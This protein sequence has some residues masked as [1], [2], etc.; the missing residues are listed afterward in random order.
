MTLQKLQRWILPDSMFSKQLKKLQVSAALNSLYTLKWCIN[1]IVMHIHIYICLCNIYGIK[2]VC[3]LHY[4]HITCIRLYINVYKC[5][6]AVDDPECTEQK[7]SKSELSVT[8]SLPL[9]SQGLCWSSTGL[10]RWPRSAPSRTWR[11]SAGELNI[12]KFGESVGGSCVSCV[13]ELCVNQ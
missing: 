2:A 1:T 9:Y 3:A 11:S 5:V 4:M 13:L 12:S 7:H 8:H 10:N 6:S